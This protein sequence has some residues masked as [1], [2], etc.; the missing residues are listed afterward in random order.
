MARADYFYAVFARAF[1]IALV[2]GFLGSMEVTVSH[3][4]EVTR[5]ALGGIPVWTVAVILTAGGPMV[6]RLHDLGFCGLH[7]PWLC[8]CLILSCVLFYLLPR[9]VVMATAGFYLLA[10]VPHLLTLALMLWP[11]AKGA[12]RYGPTSPPSA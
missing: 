11:G 4:D 6:R 3:G 12:N 9:P 2:V 5:I 1:V 7:A 10:L 8:L